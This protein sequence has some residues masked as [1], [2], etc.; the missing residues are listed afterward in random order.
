MTLSCL[1]F[2]K[3]YTFYIHFFYLI[4]L[5]CVFKNEQEGKNVRPKHL[6]ENHSFKKLKIQ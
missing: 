6:D 2:L 3:V 4:V 5:M 1:G